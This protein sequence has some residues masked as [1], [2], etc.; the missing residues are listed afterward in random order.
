MGSINFD[1]YEDDVRKTMSLSQ[2][3]GAGGG[4]FVMVDN[5][6]LGTFLKQ[7]GEWRFTTSRL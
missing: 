6:Y 7:Q 1:F 2:P 3:E 4:W 5:Y